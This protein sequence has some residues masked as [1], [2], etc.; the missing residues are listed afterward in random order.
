MSHKRNHNSSSSDLDGVHYIGE[1]RLKDSANN[2]EYLVSAFYSEVH[3][4]PIVHYYTNT[5]LDGE[6]LVRLR[7]C[8]PSALTSL[9]CLTSAFDDYDSITFKYDGV[10]LSLGGR[11]YEHAVHST[12]TDIPPPPTD[13]DKGL[14][15]E[16]WHY[17]DKY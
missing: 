6:A 15:R 8:V 9:V 10:L 4:L 3:G 14:L 2:L 13:G 7:S 5:E 17:V 1:V 11:K 16:W 12:I